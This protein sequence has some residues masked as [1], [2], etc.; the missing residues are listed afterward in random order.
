MEAYEVESKG[1]RSQ[2]YGYDAYEVLWE[3]EQGQKYGYEVQSAEMD[4]LVVV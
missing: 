3:V 2:K 1:E 4:S